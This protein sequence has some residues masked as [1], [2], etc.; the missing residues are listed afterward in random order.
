MVFDLDD[1]LYKEVDFLKSAY[2]E[3]ASTIIGKICGIPEICGLSY[4]SLRDQ[5]LTWWR[6]G[7]NVFQRLIETYHLDLTIDQLLSMYR[8]HIP[9]ISLDSETKSLLQRLSETAVLGLIT[10]GRSITQH[11]KVTALGLDAF[12]DADNI[13][14]SGD[15]G[16]EKPSE[17]P[18]RHFMQRHIT[19]NYYYV[20][21]NPSKDFVAPN[22]LGW[23]TI[24]LLDDGRNIH[25]QDFSLPQHMLP[26]HTISQI[27]EIEKIII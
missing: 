11:N 19:V 16:N 27:T 8:T 6:D 7:E 10:D 5:M 12:M 13:L 21:D 24:G 3:I 1:T 22:R 18:F 9:Q 2:T 23:T 25:H 26:Q 4:N 20:A 15:T 14:I 17:I